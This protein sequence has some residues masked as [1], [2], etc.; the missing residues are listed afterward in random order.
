MGEWA[1]DCEAR[2]HEHEDVR[3]LHLDGRGKSVDICMFV[4]TVSTLEDD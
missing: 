2:S 3:E 1:G 4:F